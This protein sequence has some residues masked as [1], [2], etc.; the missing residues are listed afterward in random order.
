[1]KIIIYEVY[2]DLLIFNDCGFSDMWEIEHFNNR[3]YLKC[4]IKQRLDGP[5]FTIGFVSTQFT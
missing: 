1:M 5:F 3:E 2:L 4:V